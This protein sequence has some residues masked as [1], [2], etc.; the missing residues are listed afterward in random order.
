MLG[1][2]KAADGKPVGILSRAATLPGEIPSMESKGR[3]TEMSERQL[4][5]DKSGVSVYVDE[6]SQH[7]ERKCDLASCGRR[8]SLRMAT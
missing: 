4:L 2:E 8:F 1:R 7:N 6:S 3:R 5:K